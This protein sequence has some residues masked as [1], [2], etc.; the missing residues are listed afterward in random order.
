MRRWR[1]PP[2]R[3]P[4][5]QRAVFTKAARG[6]PGRPFSSAPCARRQ[7][8]NRTDKEG[9]AMRVAVL[10]AGVIGVTTAWY[11]ARA[12]HEVV[13]VDRQEAAGMETSHANGGQI[14][15]SHA[16]PWA[17]P[18]APL[19]ILRWLGREDAPLLFRPQADPAQWRWALQ[20]LFECL[21][22]RTR[23]NT[24]RLVRLGLYSRRCLQELRRETGICYDHLERGILHVYDDPRALAAAQEPA[25]VMREHG[26]DLRLLDADEV[27]RIEPALRQARQLVAGG[28]LTASDESGDAFLFTQALAALAAQRGVAFR[29]GTPI[30]RLL[31][32]ASG[33]D[34][35]ELQPADGPPQVLKADAYVCALGSYSPLLLAPLGL[36]LPVYPA[37]GYSATLPIRDATMAVAGSVTDEGRKIVFTRLGERLRIAGTAELA[38]YDSGLN[39]VRCEALVSRAL[40]LFPGVARPE[41]AAYWTGLRPSTPSNLPCV[42]PTRIRNLFLNTG[43]GTLGWTHACGSASALAD[44]VSGQRPEVELPGLVAARANVVAVQRP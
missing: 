34:G 28:T 3:T 25:R 44:V 31:G 32:G 36:R 29:Y 15:V 23:R 4:A 37:K 5:A 9:H 26:C 20:F 22:Q 14:S 42:G 35:V 1:C 6:Y 24:A 7:R 19:K 21:P 39:R 2:E 40:Q 27:L 38:G 8:Q 30:R 18:G 11:L 13:V 12:G 10:G 41:E 43:H 16:L 33:I 17:N